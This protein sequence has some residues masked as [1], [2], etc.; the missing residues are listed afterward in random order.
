[1]SCLIIAE[2]SANHNNDLDT[3]LETVQA[4]I[5]SGAD[6]IKVQTYRPESLA[7]DVDNEFFGP[8]TEGPWKGWRPWDLYRHAALPYEWHEPIRTLVESQSKV[9]FSRSLSDLTPKT[10]IYGNQ[11]KYLAIFYKY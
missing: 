6:A 11:M 8:K 4:A 7:L 9:F 2:I 5:D 3:A 10:H 1:M